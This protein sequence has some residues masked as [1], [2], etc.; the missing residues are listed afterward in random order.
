MQLMPIKPPT[1]AP[2]YLETIPTQADKTMK[3]QWILI[4]NA[5][6][7]RLF[8]RQPDEPLRML[9]SFDDPDGRKRAGELASDKAGRELSGHGFGGAAF[10]PRMDAKHKEHVLFARQIAQ[11]LEH[12]ARTNS[13]ASLIVFASSPFLGELRNELGSSTTRLLAG[14]YDVDL[15]AVGPAELES[16]LAHELHD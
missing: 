11:D 7:A 12:G 13:F 3:A 1:R 15:T 6:R 14:T 10:E 9:R 16:R 4:A 2:A 5:T 8:E